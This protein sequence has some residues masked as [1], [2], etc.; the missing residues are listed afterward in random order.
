MKKTPKAGD[1]GDATWGEQANPFTLAGEN[2]SLPFGQFE[3]YSKEKMQDLEIR[4]GSIFNSDAVQD[5]GGQI[6]IR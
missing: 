2:Y 1:V 4:L 6:P 5:Y 3:W